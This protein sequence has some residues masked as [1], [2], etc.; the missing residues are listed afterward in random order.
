MKVL[1]VLPVNWNS[2]NIY[3]IKQ[4]DKTN[5]PLEA[6]ALVPVTFAHAKKTTAH[7]KNSR[8]IGLAWTHFGGG[9]CFP[10]PGGSPGGILSK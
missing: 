1:L 3:D 6:A 5:E 2:E 7:A 9:T 8:M 4:H 10:V